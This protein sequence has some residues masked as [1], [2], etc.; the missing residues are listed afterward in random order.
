MWLQIVCGLYTIRTHG[1]LPLHDWVSSWVGCR[2]G[3]ISCWHQ[4][5]VLLIFFK[6]ISQYFLCW[7]L[8]CEFFIYCISAHWSWNLSLGVI[9]FFCGTYTNQTY[10]FDSP[11][12]L[13]K[14]VA[15]LFILLLYLSLPTDWLDVRKSS[16][17]FYVD[18][19]WFLFWQLKKQH[20]NWGIYL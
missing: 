5:Y 8:I 6:F 18:F 11:V 19:C 9:W 12:V 20:R 7:P 14:V 17:G 10:L 4:S 3:P 2:L 1:F 13:C 16:Q 15:R